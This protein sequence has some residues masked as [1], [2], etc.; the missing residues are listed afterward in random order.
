MKRIFKEQD[1]K[2]DFFVFMVVMIVACS[3]LVSKYCINGHD[4]EYHLLRIESLKEG[5]LMGKPFLRINT[6]FLGGAG[7]ASSLFY[8]D[9]LL[10]ISAILRVMGVGINAGY[11]IV[12]ALSIC[13]TYLST[14]YCVKKMT[15]SVYPAM[16]AGLLVVLSPYYLGDV[17][18]RGAVGEYFAFIFLPFVVYGIYN[19]L[20]E[21]MSKPWI[22]AIGFGGVLLT[23]TNSF[24]FCIAF[25][26]VA[27]IVKWKAFKDN[28]KVLWKL[29][30]TVGITMAVTAFYW[31]PVLEMLITTPLYVNTA[32]IGLEETAI[33]FSAIFS[34]EFPSLGF[35]LVILA[36]PRILVK[37]NSQNRNIIGFADWLLVGGAIFAVLTTDIIPWDRLNKYLSFVQFP[38]RLFC[39][40]TVMLAMADA[41]VLYCFIKSY[42][43][44]LMQSSMK[45]LTILLLII[46]S[47]LAFR[48]ISNADITYYDYSDDYYSYKPFTCNIIAGEWLPEAVESV[49]EISKNSDHMYDEAGNDVS[50]V[51]VKNTIEADIKEDHQ[52]VDVPFVYYRGYTATIDGEDGTKQN[53]SIDGSGNNGLLRVKL[54]GLRGHL[55]V[56]YSGTVLQWIST[57][58]SMMTVALLIVE[59]IIRRKNAKKTSDSE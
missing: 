52:Y 9:F 14:H 45:V 15:G 40:A 58:L 31:I 12:V 46:A 4:L 22:L 51:R 53:L 44:P 23:H 38:W 6:L 57:I 28:I 34:S 47:A 19:T 2:I 24:I 21:E 41:I 56:K 33:Q 37:K 55:K 7:Y 35:L 43:E 42:M 30:A 18:I 49:G 13:L 16:M 10:Y 11:H 5:I 26:L 27:F 36:F 48:F 20:Y 1:N 8:P 54:N 25:G 17:F 39:L 50:F 59:R 32:W 29:L 3:P